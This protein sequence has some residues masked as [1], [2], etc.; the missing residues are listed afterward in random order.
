MIGQFVCDR[1]PDENNMT[2]SDG[3]DEFSCLRCRGRMSEG[4]L[5]LSFPSGMHLGMHEAKVV[6]V[7]PG[8]KTNLNPITA[9]KQGL[10]DQPA[11]KEHS[12]K[13]FCSEQCGRIEFFCSGE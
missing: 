13:A 8:I 12:I 10:E 1:D 5:T 2:T 3:D 4:K 6:F 11:D 9:F 7:A